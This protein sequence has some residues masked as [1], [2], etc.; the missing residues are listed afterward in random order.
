MRYRIPGQPATTSMPPSDWRTMS[1]SRARPKTTATTRLAEV[2]SS[3]CRTRP[4]VRLGLAA[5]P[6]REDLGRVG[7]SWPARPAWKYRLA[8]PEDQFISAGRGGQPGPGEP[9]D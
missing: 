6:S 7:T 9:G 1:I 5:G 4:R 3:R 2:T 8:E